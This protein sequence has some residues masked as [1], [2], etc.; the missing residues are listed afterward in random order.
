[1]ITCVVTCLY[2]FVLS[3]EEFTLRDGLCGCVCDL[4][5]CAFVFLFTV[6]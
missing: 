6:G 5:L 3:F 2:V 4:E 1:M